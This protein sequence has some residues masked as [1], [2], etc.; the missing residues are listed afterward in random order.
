MSFDIFHIRHFQAK[1]FP[2][3]VKWWNQHQQVAPR[4][5]MMP[6]ESSFIVECEGLPLA[7]ITVYLTNASFA[8]LDNLVGNPEAPKDQRKKA[9]DALVKH[10]ELVAAELGKLNLFCMSHDKATTRRYVGLGYLPTL[11]N[12]TTHS[13]EIK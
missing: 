2:E 1:D 8:W 11:S 7:A 3:V 9:V 5:D 4:L 10:C 12:V 6:E 13:K